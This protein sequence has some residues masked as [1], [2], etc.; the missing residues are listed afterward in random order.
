MV[1]LIRLPLRS[2]FPKILSQA[3]VMR[4][5]DCSNV[6]EGNTAWKAIRQFNCLS[7]YKKEKEIE[8]K[9]AQRSHIKTETKLGLEPVFLGP[10][11]QFIPLPQY[12]HSC[13]RSVLLH[14]ET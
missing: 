2:I 1:S 10:S 3:K 11:F 7:L 6:R 9:F 13:P 4:V 5:N 14:V 12:R 8:R